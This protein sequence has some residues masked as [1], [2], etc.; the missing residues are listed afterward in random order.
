M[1][2]ALAGGFGYTIE[3]LNLSPGAD[4]VLHVQDVQG[5]YVDGNDDCGTR[6]ASCSGL[7]S[8]LHIPAAMVPR[9][10]RIIVRAY[11]ALSGGTATLRITPSFG[12]PTDV[13]IAFTGGYRKSLP[14]FQ[15]SSHFMT[16]EE[17]GGSADT[18]LLITSGHAGRAISF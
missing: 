2:Y 4:T 9:T 10:V 3:T 17:Q 12:V 18:I 7:R 16:T 5:N 1:N 11:S 14:S 6:N 8:W 15:V 13:A